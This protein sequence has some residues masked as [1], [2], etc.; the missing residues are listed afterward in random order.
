MFYKVICCWRDCTAMWE[1]G[2]PV[3]VSHSLSRECVSDGVMRNDIF[4]AY[5][6]IQTTADW[7]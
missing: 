6:E 5:M 3:S 2:F 7:L 4:L 1:Y